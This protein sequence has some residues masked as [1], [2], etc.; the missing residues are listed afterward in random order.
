MKHKTTRNPVQVER[1]T[2]MSEFAKW[3]MSKANLEW[4]RRGRA[5]WVR[6]YGPISKSF[7]S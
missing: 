1:P 5:E 2:K 7:P 3:F 4:L 6:R